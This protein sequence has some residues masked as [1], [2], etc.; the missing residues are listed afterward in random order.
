MEGNLEK[1]DQ[2]KLVE[3]DLQVRKSR[4]QMKKGLKQFENMQES[5]DELETTLNRTSFDD[6]HNLEMESSVLFEPYRSI[7][8]VTA[9][10]PFYVHRNQDERLMTVSVDHAFHVY[11][12]EKL[13]LVYISNSV[14]QKIMQLQTHSNYTYTLLSNNSI[15]KW[16][17]MHPEQTFSCFDTPVIQFLVISSYLLVLC[18]GGKLYTVDLNTQFIKAKAD[19]GMNAY[20]FMH[21]IT[22]LN[23]IVVAGEG[24]QLM[25]YNIEAQEVI[26]NFK[27]ITKKLKGAKVLAMEQSPLVDIV[28]MGLESGDLLVVNLKQDKVLLSFTQD[29]PAKSISFSTDSTLEK[30]LLASCTTDGNILFWDLNEK[31]IHSVIQK[32]HNSKPIDKVQFLNNEP[33]LLSSSGEDNSVKMWLFDM[34]HGSNVAPRLLKERSGHSDTPHIIKYYG[35]DGKHI[36]SSSE[37]TF[38]RNNS[39]INEH[40]SRNFSYKKNLAKKKVSE[41]GEDIGKTV[42]FSFAELRER[43]WP[44]VVTCHSK[45]YTPFVWS[46]ENG[47]LSEVSK[48]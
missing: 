1:V 23:K 44:N 32:A 21:P 26:Y 42:D 38:L 8:Y 33:I 41:L 48:Y 24:D 15:I 45:A 10:T 12:L 16:R 28:A 36:L 11:N 13:S 6:S 35:D 3:Q 22:Y 34:E 30:S 47:A 46:K 5:D 4:K 2:S 7:G 14:K 9:A 37:N 29:S 43:D 25:V 39:L 19:L 40:I 27:N 31:K 20:A 17:R 18:E